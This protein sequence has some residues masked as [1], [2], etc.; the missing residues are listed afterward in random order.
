MPAGRPLLCRNPEKPWAGLGFRSLLG[1]GVTRSVEDMPAS[2]Q[3]LRMGDPATCPHCHRPLSDPVLLIAAEVERI[4]ELAESRAAH[5]VDELTGQVR[6]LQGTVA[7]LRG[8]AS[9][10]Y[11]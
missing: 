9:G 2:D 5:R 6:R 4:R 7:N 8:R 3:E 10:G 1:V 11:R